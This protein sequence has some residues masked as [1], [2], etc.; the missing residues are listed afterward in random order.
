MYDVTYEI[1]EDDR[2]PARPVFG[3]LMTRILELE[4]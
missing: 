3:P 4:I 2:P 1:E